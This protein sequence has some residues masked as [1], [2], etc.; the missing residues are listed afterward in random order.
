MT[1]A[2]EQFWLAVQGP[3][4]APQPVCRALHR[5]AQASIGAR[6]FSVMQFDADTRLAARLYTS[7]PLNYPLAG[8]KPLPDNH[9]T[10]QVIDRQRM[11]VANDLAGVAAVFADHAL[12]D[13]LGCQAVINVPIV[14]A[15]TVIGTINCL[16]AAGRYP[17]RAAAVAT[18]LQVPGLVALLAERDAPLPT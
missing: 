8:T 6:L 3:P 5:L 4:G 11:F 16:D 12:I 17:P 10:E 14:L 15:G 13:S 9:W 18:S 1:D 7:D 2:V